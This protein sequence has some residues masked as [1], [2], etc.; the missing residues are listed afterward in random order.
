M[1]NS[2]RPLRRQGP[3]P[4]RTFLSLL[5]AGVAVCFALFIALH[6]RH[7]LRQ[8]ADKVANHA[9]VIS[10]SLWTY[11]KSSPTAYLQLAAEANGYLEVV[12]RDEVGNEF[13][14]LPGPSLS[15][16]DGLLSSLG[17][18]RTH[19]I[20]AA[21]SYEGR[22]IGTIVAVWPC[23]AIHLYLYV[24][25]CLVLLLAVAGLV[26]RLL[27]A[28]RTLEERVRQR[29]EEL[30]GEVLERKR[31]EETARRQAERLALHVQ[32]TPL[33][34]IEWNLD[35][36][37][38]EWNRAAERIFGY[39]REEALG[40]VPYELIVTAEERPEVD[41]V[42]QQLITGSGGSWSINV[43][44]TKAGA[45]KTCE[46]Y[47]TPLT[48]EKGEIF[49]VASL[50]LDQSE[51]ARADLENRR[52]QEQLLQAQKMEAIGN[53]AGGVAHDFN[54]MLGV[55][56]GHT[57]MALLRVDHGQP[58]YGHLQEVLKAAS[59][60]ADITRQLLAFARKQAVAPKVLDLNSL[61]EGMLKMLRR[62]IGE[63]VELSWLPRGDLW[64]VKVDPAQI[65]QILVNLCVNARDALP[66]GR[67]KLT[68]ET[69]NMV[70][71]EEYCRDH[72]GFVAGNYVRVSVSD[73]GCGMDKE[74][75][76]HIFEPFFT[77]KGVGE[78]T[79][80]GM[81]TVYG[82]V[83]Q[84]GG[85][86][87]VYSEVGQG[88]TVSIYLPRHAGEAGDEEVADTAAEPVRG[89]SETILLV[90][91]E[92]AILKM[93]RDMLTH[94]GYRVLT[95]ESPVAAV[96]LLEE[97]GGE[98]H[99]LITD[100]VMPEM[101]GKELAELLNQRQPGLRCLFTSGYT[102]TVIASH[103]ILEEGIDFIQKPF[104]I[105]DLADKVRTVL[106]RRKG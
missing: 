50:V 12:V 30:Q 21:I 70:F 27:E 99:L 68:V 72:N 58:L 98:V 41:G 75:L 80:L 32:H 31:A 74:T 69:G 34:V 9:A 29:T 78:G 82:A 2:P 96:S 87:N 51:K 65:D 14:S 61:I 48:N 66:V 85:F 37:V 22:N 18:I 35:F 36:E 86:V 88:T 6:H 5:V 71:D 13:L 62:L 19:A 103:G 63:G 25:L 89:G 84:N 91:D 26:A 39:R 20:E 95:A 17:M 100:V 43:N 77:T 79:G 4:S 46:W 45:L 38:V 49:G 102:G 7:T 28:K 104:S 8:A 56:L 64:P 105:K 93:S 83:R 10:S 11:E 54:N 59:R 23:R 81:A 44:R 60:S 24:F 16:V 67:G 55:I 42:W 40:R 47:N 94:L 101:N 97:H 57:E 106:D 1:N 15:A 52:L 90:E 3:K 76:D 53:L 33:A 92:A 73:N